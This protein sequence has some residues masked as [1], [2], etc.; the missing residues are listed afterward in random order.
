MRKK[1][2]RQ[3]P[4]DFASP[5]KLVRKHYSLYKAIAEILDKNPDILNAVH[6][7]LC[8]GEKKQKRNIEGVSSESILRMAVV[9]KVECLSLR[10]LIISVADSDMLRFFCKIYDDPMIDFTTFCKLLNM[11][12]P[13][14]WEKINRILVHYG[15][16]KKGI[17]GE[18]LR[19]DT[20]AV[21]TDVHYPTD[22][23]LLY[24]C[25][26]KLSSLI[27]NVRQS[28]ASLAG[29]RRARVK[30]ARKLA[31]SLAYQLR[32]KTEHKATHRKLYRKLIE[33]AERTVEWSIEVRQ[34]I[35]SSMEKINRLNRIELQWL[36]KDLQTY[37]ERA[38]KCIHQAT[39]RVLNG[40]PVP[41]EEK[42]FSIFEP[43]TELIKRGKAGQE[44]EFG[45]M[46]EVQQVEGGLITGYTSHLKRPAEAGLI[47]P[48]LH[49]HKNIFGRTPKLCATDKGF[50]SKETVEAAEALGVKTIA[51]PKKGSRNEAEDR[52]EHSRL[53]KLGQCFRAGIEAA[54]SY[55]KR[56]FGFDR[57]LRE[58]FSRFESW[59]GAGV[60]AHNLVTL[61][62]L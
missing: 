14:T 7:D 25:V 31:R 57:C 6:A 45:H 51:I 52:W 60:F 39:Q 4:L 23:S 44:V 22:S 9:Q 24:D 37:V 55:L 47:V 21:E 17:K 50:Y 1:A 61:A 11:I 5:L 12:T 13:Q 35:H 19:I 34:N 2:D 38:K 30:D 40:T 3:L 53:F 62:K 43:H 33:A 54:F 42:I 32:G 56:V 41:N 16:D 10:G 59:V 48:A 27:G 15:R 26:D 18:K 29:N 8:A 58:G 46:V 36:A 28:M 49:A 20:T